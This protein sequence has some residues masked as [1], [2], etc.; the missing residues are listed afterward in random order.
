MSDN[1]KTLETKFN[2]IDK[3]PSFLHLVK[4]ADL[5]NAKA[6]FIKNTGA[7]FVETALEGL[8]GL[9]KRLDELKSER[10]KDEEARLDV[11]QKRL[12]FDK[13][14]INSDMGLTD[15][16]KGEIWDDYVAVSN[17]MDE[18]YAARDADKKDEIKQAS[19]KKNVL[20]GSSIVGG[21]VI[22]GSVAY[23]LIQ[24]FMKK[25]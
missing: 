20:I 7:V 1:A 8:N 12:D 16:K 17:K 4:E 18:I 3:M 5:G 9:Q 10:R 15:E 19:T 24:A 22:L 13:S 25:R 11:L 6:N 2:P 14:L 23:G 21:S